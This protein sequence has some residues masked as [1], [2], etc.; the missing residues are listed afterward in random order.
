VPTVK[1][2]EKK[3]LTSAAEY[4]IIKVNRA[5]GG[6]VLT[7]ENS[8]PAG[9]DE[10]SDSSAMQ[11]D[12]G[13]RSVF[14]KK[15]NFLHFLTKYI[16]ASWAA[17]ISED[18]LEHVNATFVT[19]DYQKRE[20]DVVYRLKNENVFFY[21]LLELQSESDFTMPFRLLNYMVN[22]LAH[23]FK[24]TPEVLR[25]RKDFR[26]PAIVPIV[27]YNGEGNWT[28]VRSYNRVYG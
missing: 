10:S 17:D 22:L 25:E 18:N 3:F 16:K 4:A 12:K 28:P 9:Q 27:L 6:A 23:E 7:D 24:N 14:A 20:S 13:Y 1:G 2:L 26:L 15:D 11:H 19:K 21:V 5:K 8:I